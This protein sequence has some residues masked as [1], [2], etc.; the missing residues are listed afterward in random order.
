[1]AVGVVAEPDN[2][3]AVQAWGSTN[4]GHHHPTFPLHLPSFWVVLVEI[5]GAEGAALNQ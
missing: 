5:K 4:K 3:R 1:M 2:G